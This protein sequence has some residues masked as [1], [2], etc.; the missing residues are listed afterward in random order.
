MNMYHRP[1]RGAIAVSQLL[2]GAM[3]NTCEWPWE[4]APFRGRGNRDGLQADRGSTGSLASKLLE[5]LVDIT[6]E[7]ATAEPANPGSAV[8]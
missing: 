2:H 6:P 4:G 3:I 1:H 5:R 7:T 8:A